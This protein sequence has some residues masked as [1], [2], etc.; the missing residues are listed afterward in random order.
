M[1]FPARTPI[2]SRS[3][4]PPLGFAHPPDDRTAARIH[5]QTQNAFDGYQ[6]LA[7]R[8]VL[9]RLDSPRGPVAR[10]DSGSHLR[11]VNGNTP[12]KT[13]WGCTAGPPFID[14]IANVR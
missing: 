5:A 4:R 3:Q 8:D 14:Q 2:D 10:T 9:L 12:S 7:L 13:V 1:L 11:H 6:P